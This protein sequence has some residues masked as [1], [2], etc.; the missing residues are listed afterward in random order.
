MSPQLD[1]DHEFQYRELGVDLFSIPLH[2]DSFNYQPQINVVEQGPF[3]TLEFLHFFRMR[4]DS[5]PTG[6]VEN[7]P[8]R[9]SAG[10]R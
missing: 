2:R 1:F 5:A 4:Q 3:R 7:S 6:A 9:L 10:C 8:A